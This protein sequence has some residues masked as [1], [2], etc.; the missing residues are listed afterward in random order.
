MPIEVTLVKGQDGALRPASAADQE[1]MSKFKIGQAVR[2]SVVQ[3]K[4]RSLQHH[5]LYWGGL[6]ELAM[7]YWEPTGGLVSSSETSTL[8]RFA[9]WLDKQGG[10][11]GA[12][13]RACAAFLDELRHSRG[14]RIDAPHKSREALH[15]WIKVEAGYFEYAMTPNGVTKRALSINFNVMDQSQFNDFYKSAFNVC[16]RFILSRTFENEDQADSAINQLLAFG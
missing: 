12:I 6:I 11:S 5:R 14:L 15:E 13:R 4:S 3:I 2:V 8:K 1:H 16:W 7:D 10:N 9:D